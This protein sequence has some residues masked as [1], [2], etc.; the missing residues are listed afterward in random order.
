MSQKTEPQKNEK[1]QKFE[2]DP[3]TIKAI[4]AQKGAEIQLEAQ[5]L[6]IEEKRIDRDGKLSERSMELNSEFLK[7]YPKQHRHTVI[8]YGIFITI[9]IFGI[10]FFIGYCVN[11]GNKELAKDVLT[12]ITHITTLVVG[13]FVG[14]QS[15]KKKSKDP[16][17]P[18]EPEDAEIV[19]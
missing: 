9:I 4:V 12:V 8:T 2:L 14:K 16:A 10:L 18:G 3:D 11:T 13:I 6:K 1:N 17:Q 7:N 5:R 15:N 19:D